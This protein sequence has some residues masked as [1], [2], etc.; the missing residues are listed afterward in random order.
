MTLNQ[1]RAFLLTVRTGSFTAAAAELKMAQ[2]SVSEL[3]RRM[4]EEAGLALFIRGG[5]RLVLTS[6]GA[7]LLPFA[8]QAV[9]S[10]DEGRAALRS[11]GSLD[12]G[13]VTF[14]LL[15]NASY[16][17]LPDLAQQFHEAFPNVRLRLV[18]Q[19]SS[20]V[21]AAVSKGELEAGLVVLPV[22]DAGL[23]V[24]PLIRDEVF[25]ASAD[26]ERLAAPMTIHRMA[27]ADLVMYDARYGWSDPTRRQ[28]AERAQLEGLRI[29][30]IIEVEHVEAA[31]ALVARGVG[32]T[33]ISRAVADSPFCP[34]EVGTVSFAEPLYDTIA[35]IQRTSSVLSPGARE[36]ARRARSTLLAGITDPAQRVY[37]AT[38]GTA[39]RRPG[40]S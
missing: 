14:G 8:E 19:N 20:E 13:A 29:E 32:D 2:A 38:G 3:I 23:R 18:G 17:L 12:G 28:I 9:S 37:P 4:E 10:V 31:L 5:R 1:L 27:E 26:P 11:I 6:A 7:E 35:F 15:R 36:L 34:P 16:Y 40:V 22:E 24:T 30:P 21:A 33:I 25:Y 39:R